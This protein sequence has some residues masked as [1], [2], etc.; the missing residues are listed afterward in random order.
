MT[1]KIFLT[2]SCAELVMGL[3]GICN[4]TLPMSRFILWGFLLVYAAIV[5]KGYYS[6]SEK[7]LL[8]VLLVFGALLYIN[9]GIN[10][11]IKAP[12]YLYALKNVDIKKYCKV[13]FIILAVATLGI[14]IASIFAGF[15][16][17]YIID[18]R[19][20]RGFNGLRYCFGFP[21]PNRTMA[22]ILAV[23]LLFL[24]L[25]GDKT[26]W[27][28]YAG[29]AA[30]YAG[31]YYFTNSRTA[32]LLGIFIL[33]LSFCVNYVKW[34]GWNTSVFILFICAFSGMLILSILAA[35]HYESD[36]MARIDHIISG[37]MEQLGTYPGSE[38]DALPYVENWHLFGSRQNQGGYD[39]GYVQ[40][41]YYYGIV[42]AICYLVF[43]MYAAVK[44]WKDKRAGQLVVLFGFSI[45]LFMENV[46]FSNFIPIN[47]LLVYSAVIV[48][49]IYEREEKKSVSGDFLSI[50][51]C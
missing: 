41:F 4:V 44:A 32:F 1:E 8:G 7:L 51:N 12:L 5:L 48:W 14:I 45:Y 47:F 50:H 3:L 49:G 9:S 6:R 16:T 30:V 39:L 13:S 2:I 34:D 33:I 43:V 11:G 27:Y 38:S 31:F 19:S 46:Y 25:Y 20:Y 22:V 26:K 23:M 40:I 28:G 10:T 29:I 18:I 42:P 35:S 24:N 15:G 37:R 17:L 21:N 36:W